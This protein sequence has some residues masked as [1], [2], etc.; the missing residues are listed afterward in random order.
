MRGLKYNRPYLTYFENSDR[1][2][3]YAG[4]VFAVAVRRLAASV[5][6]DPGFLWVGGAR[7]P[8]LDVRR[9]SLRR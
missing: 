9:R 8:W 5:D 2:T 7:V 6:H 4:G 3:R 1:M